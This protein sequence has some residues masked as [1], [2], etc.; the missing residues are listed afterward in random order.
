MEINIGCLK[1]DK[2]VE[3]GEDGSSENEI[4]IEEAMKSMEKV[5]KQLKFDKFIAEV[6]REIVLLRYAHTV[7]DEIANEQ[8]KSEQKDGKS[9]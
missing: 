8:E 1:K 9:E 3:T 5:N 7:V 6:A 4:Y 2:N